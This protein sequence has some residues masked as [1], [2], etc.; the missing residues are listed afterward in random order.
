MPR[1]N[2]RFHYKQTS[3]RYLKRLRKLLSCL[4]KADGLEAF[5]VLDRARMD[6]SFHKPFGYQYPDEFL[7]AKI[8]EPGAV[9]GW[10]LEA[11]IT[12]SMATSELT[13]PR[14]LNAKSWMAIAALVNA[15][16]SV[17]NA[18]AGLIEPGLIWR[19]IFRTMHR[20]TP[21]QIHDWNTADAVRWWSIFQSDPLREIFRAQVGVSL[22]KF[23]RMGMAWNL[24]LSGS[25][26]CNRPTASSDFRVTGEEINSFL[27]AVSAPLD[28]TCALAR[29]VV[30]HSTEIDFRRSALRQKPVI[31]L[32]NAYIR[33]Y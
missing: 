6:R 22:R 11:L 19:S 14:T 1:P 26:Y 9:H 32:G 28:E 20:Q 13:G 29:E 23:V 4:P 31:A 12:E 10:E 15:L 3:G 21:W 16:R 7:F 33:P 18:Q 27:S 2:P 8:G 25:P 17:G 30:R 5:W 24:I